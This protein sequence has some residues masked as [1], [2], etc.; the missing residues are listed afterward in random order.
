MHY[1]TGDTAWV[2]TSSAAVLFMTPGLAFFYAGM[3]RRKNVLAMLMQNYVTMAIVGLIWVW[4]TY[5]LAFG[6]DWGGAGLLGTLHFAGL[7]HLSQAVPGFSGAKAMTIP[8]V[9]FV[10]FQM[11]FA[12][13]TAALLSG[14]VAERM[15]FSAWV[16]FIAIWSIVV[17]APIAHWVFSP[18]GWLALRGT[19]DFAGGTVVE[20]TSGMSGAALALVLGRRAG[21]PRQMVRPHNVP[22]TVLGAGVL[23]FGW[24]GFNA[25]SALRAADAGQAFINTNTATAAALLTW[26]VVEKARNGKP[27]TL[28]AVTG[29]IAGAVAITPACGY[30]NTLGATVIGAVAGVGCALAVGLKHRLRL[31]DSLDVLAV[32][33][34]AGATGMILLGLFGTASVLGQNGLLYGGGPALLGQQ[35]LGVVTVAAYA[36][37]ATALIAVVVRVTI[38]LRVSEDDELAGLDLALHEETAY[39]FDPAGGARRS[40]GAGRAAASTRKENPR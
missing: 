13:I 39:D 34:V 36:F 18:N 16:V 33:F 35:A 2:L 1:D 6:P 4:V 15:K 11:M 21:W 24:F 37:G 27:T 26:L 32:H 12:V 40:A 10:A 8:P 25:G 14:S 38:G 5:S 7:G 30:V 22:F 29:A 9:V 28:G 23:W 17:Y 3:V 31:D 20:V 19:E